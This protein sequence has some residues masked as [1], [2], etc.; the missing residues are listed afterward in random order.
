MRRDE[1]TAA[2][3][4]EIK[5]VC[6]NPKCNSLLSGNQQRHCSNK[7]KQRCYR[8][9]KKREKLLEQYRAERERTQLPDL[10]FLIDEL[11]DLLKPDLPAN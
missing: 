4:D 5:N 10:N 7:C 11:S 1:G 2:T 8:L 9:R 3:P 6:A